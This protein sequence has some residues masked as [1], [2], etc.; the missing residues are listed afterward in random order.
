MMNKEIVSYQI[1]Q[2]S[3]S[4]DFKAIANKIIE[5]QRIS[6]EECL[7]LYKCNDLPLLGILANFINREKNKNQVYFNRNF[8]IEPSNICRYSCKFCSYRK[9]ASLGYTLSKEEILNEVSN[10][11][12]DGITEVHI[13]GSAHPD[14]NLEF[15]EDLLYCIRKEYPR[16]HI[17]AFSAI[18]LFSIFELSKVSITEGL[19]RLKNAGLQSI[20]GGGAEIFDE[21]IRKQICNDKAD[22]KFWLEIHKTAH[23]LGLSSNATMLYGHI[24]SYENR[25]DHLDRL[26]S[27]QDETHGFNAF[28]PLKFLHVNNDM[29]SI[30]ESTIVED[31]K[32]FAVARIFLDNFQHIKSYWPMLGKE[33]ASLALNFGADDMDGTID[34]TTK[35]YTTAGSKE[36]SP[37]MNSEELIKIIHE[38]NRVAVERD[39]KYN[40]IKIFPLEINR[41]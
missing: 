12:K 10:H 19:T 22:A 9:E 27:L 33:E 16:L 29:S 35:I 2:M 23:Q 31:M 38:N 30:E 36:Q 21:T 15:Y 37:M 39:S 40:V 6:K 41:R 5:L 24:E 11:Y 28:I 18:E 26:R 17:K 32:N 25:I 1:S 8:H 20:P 4:E 34:D 3:I 7:I 14:R 13:V